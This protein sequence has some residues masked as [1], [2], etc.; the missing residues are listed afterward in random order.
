MRTRIFRRLNHRETLEHSQ[1]TSDFYAAAADKP[2][3]EGK[4]LAALPPKR[5][6]RRPVDKRPVGPTE[7]QEQCVVIS[8]WW[9][10]HEIYA[11]PGFAL[12]AVPNGGARDPI[13]GSRLKAE[14]VRRGTPDLILARPTA[15]YH[16]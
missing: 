14:G 13:T 9:L 6:I 5:E 12:F 3:I 8:W 11:I 1:R 4:L 2:R 10:Q 16:G 7:H 15:R